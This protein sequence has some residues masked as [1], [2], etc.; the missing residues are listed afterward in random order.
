V[1][2]NLLQLDI[3]AVIKINKIVN[4]GDLKNTYGTGGF[5]L[6]VYLIYYSKG[7]LF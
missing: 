3:D 5:L 1:T 2:N 7:I 4:E 6:M